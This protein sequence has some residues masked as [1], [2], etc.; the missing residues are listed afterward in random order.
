MSVWEIK[1]DGNTKLADIYSDDLMEIR[2]P[3][4]S[5][6]TELI[7]VGSTAVL[8]LVDSGEQIEG[9]VK[10]VAKQGRNSFRWSSGKICDHYCK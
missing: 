5:G 3:F 8:T 6:E 10:A 4:L 1:S 9:T 7:P 2:I